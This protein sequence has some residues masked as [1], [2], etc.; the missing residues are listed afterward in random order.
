M[1]PN[2]YA[3]LMFLDNDDMFHPVRIPWFQE[4]VKKNKNATAIDGIFSGGKLLIDDN[5]VREKFGHEQ[6]PEIELFLYLDPALG[7]VV[8][9]AATQ[10]ENQVKDV[11]E[12]F[13]L[14][15]R[16]TVLK[17]FISFTPDGILSHRLCDVRYSECVSKLKILV[18]N[19]PASEWLLMHY[20]I[21]HWDGHQ[22][23]LQKDTSRRKAIWEERYHKFSSYFDSDLARKN[24]Q[25]RAASNPHEYDLEED[26]SGIVEKHF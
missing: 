5:K 7:G 3:W 2:P 18:C 22:L 16:S 17:K 23:F 15:V 11:T 20:R 12:Y 4:P 26:L 21:R 13:D 19:H 1:A 6:V 14:C 8:D 25:W 10:H 24:R 9:V